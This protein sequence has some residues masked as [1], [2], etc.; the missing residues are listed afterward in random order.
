VTILVSFALSLEYHPWRRLRPFQRSAASIPVYH[1]RIGDSTVRVVITGIGPDRAAAAIGLTLNDPPHVL[2]SSGLAGGLRAQLRCGAIVAARKVSDH[3]TAHHI[4]ADARLVRAAAAG[5][6]TVIDTLLSAERIVS[7]AAERTSLN[8]LAEAV[9]MESFAWLSSAAERGI[10]AIALRAIGDAAGR[11]LPLDFNEI[12]V[13]RRAI[14]VAGVVAE[15]VRHPSSLPGLARLGV[16]NYPA[17]VRLAK[18][19]DAYVARLAS[20]QDAETE[21]SQSA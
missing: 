9:D 10:P 7:T 19:I 8:T 3:R 15:L 20:P 5:G 12:L 6:A 18:F 14:T 11:D 1:T 4:R 2:I 13:R 21:L 17:A 16:D